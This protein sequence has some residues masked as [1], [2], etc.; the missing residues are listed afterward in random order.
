MAT[1]YVVLC[2]ADDGKGWEELARVTAP[3]ARRARELGA[4]QA[5]SEAVEAGIYLRAVP[6]RNWDGGGG[7]VKA[8]THRRIRSA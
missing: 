2:E 7:E 3:T 8:E 1:T 4:E 6:V 5:D